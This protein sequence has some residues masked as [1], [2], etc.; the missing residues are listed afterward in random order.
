MKA[1]IKTF[2]RRLL[3]FGYYYLIYK[4]IRN[5]YEK[6][7]DNK[8]LKPGISAVVAAKNEEILIGYCLESLIGFADQ[9]ICIDNGSDDGTLKIMQSFSE[10]NKDIIDISIISMPGALLGECREMG[11]KMTKHQWH[12]RWDADMVFKT[13]G[14]E[15]AEGLRK[16]VLSCS[17]PVAFQLPRTN[18]FGDFK[19]TSK[20][21]DIVDP[22]EPILV[23]FAKN[24]KYV[25]HGR[26][27][28]IRLP[29][30][31]K[32]IKEKK[33]YYHHFDGVKP[34]LR[35]MYRNCYF[36]W[37]EQFNKAPNKDKISDFETFQKK[38]QM[39]RYQTN[40]RKSLK[41]RFQKEYLIQ[42]KLYET[43]IYGDYPDVIK[44]L[45]YN[46]L[47]RFEIEYC[48]GKPIRRID[49][50]DKEM[51]D[52]TPTLSDLEYDPIPY[53]KSKLKPKH[54]NKLIG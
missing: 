7:R 47:G 18:L 46:S 20:V 41:Y 25:E 49:R 2:L 15:M 10:K 12:L 30:Y 14:E 9:V 31:Y 13:T 22:G 36:D 48:K 11:L 27:D 26:F 3:S 53:L 45:I 29:F 17:K 8:T 52:Y 23:R 38:W 6:T 54:F 21:Y 32:T 42:L 37:R 50:N 1:K 44:K 5:Q 43:E 39:E 4:F 16:K 33:R 34:D 28:I 40:D 35:L 51:L 24:I 19:H